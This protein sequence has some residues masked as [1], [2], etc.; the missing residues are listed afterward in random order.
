MVNISL[1]SALIFYSIVLI[2]FFKTRK[3]WDVH[4]KI[5]A[6]YKTKLGLKSMERIAKSNPKAIKFVGYVGVI[7]GFIGMV[8]IFLTLIKSSIDIFFGSK[9]AGL[10]PVLPGVKIPGL[11]TLSFWHWLIGIFVLAVVHEFA[12]GVLAKVHDLEVKSSGF[13][14]FGP[15]MLAF[16][17]PDEKKLIK[18]SKMTQLSVF[19]AGPLSN[20][21]FGALFGLIFFFVFRLIGIVVFE[22]E[23]FVVYN[24]TEGYDIATKNLELPFTILSINDINVNDEKFL[25]IF[26]EL[27]PGEK[28]KLNTDKGESI[29]MTGDNPNDKTK[30]Y[31]G[32]VGGMKS[33]LREKYEDYLVIE[34][35]YGWFSLMFF[36]LFILNLGVGLFNLIPLSVVDGG[37]MF[38]VLA[39]AIFKNEKKAK[40]IWSLVTYIILFLIFVNLVPWF[41]KLFKFITGLVVN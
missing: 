11:P 35:V 33:K 17:E 34:K 41:S 16:V 5:I 21:I 12:H 18:K 36:W 8:F 19:A 24:V 30:G 4:G 20:F 38:Y 27:K 23:G 2:F 22:Y 6:L 25:K 14:F 9:V 15:I 13:G 1:I 29:V 37:R 32:I 3:R 31:I 10:A 39:Q 28:L 7:L 26:D 40:N